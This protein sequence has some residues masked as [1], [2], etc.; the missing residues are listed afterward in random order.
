MLRFVRGQKR[1]LLLL[2]VMMVVVFMSLGIHSYMLYQQTLETEMTRLGAMANSQAQFLVTLYQTAQTDRQAL[3][4][5]EFF[6][7]LLVNTYQ[8]W[9][10]G[11]GDT[12][13]VTFAHYRDGKIEF[14]F[15]RHPAHDHSVHART[16]GPETE[17]L[18]VPMHRALSGG[19]GVVIAPD[20]RGVPVLAAY[21]FIAPLALG[22]VIKIDLAEIRAPL[23]DKLGKTALVSLLLLVVGGVFFI[24]ISEGITQQIHESQQTFASIFAGASDGILLMESRSGCLTMANGSFCAMVGCA[25]DEIPRLALGDLDRDGVLIQFLAQFQHNDEEM[26]RSISDVPL[27][28]RDGTL[29]YADINLSM[30]VLNRRIHWLILCRDAT[31]RRQA[32]TIR[33]VNEDWLRYMTA[34]NHWDI[35]FNVQALCDQALE[36]AETLTHSQAGFLYLLNDDRNTFSLRSQSGDAEACGVSHPSHAPIAE[37]GVWADSV[38]SVHAT[39]CND[40]PTLATR[41]GLPAGHKPITRYASVPVLIQG[42]VQMILVVGNKAQPYDDGDIQQLQIVGNDVMNLIMRK[43]WEEQLAQSKEQA[44]AA[45]RA[46]ADFLAAMSHEIRTPMNGVLGMADLILGTPLTDQQRH[47]VETIHR[48]GRTLLRIINDILDLSKIQAGQLLLDPIPFDLGEVIRDI[49]DLFEDGAAKKGLGFHV[50]VAQGV[51]VY[52]LGDPYRLNQI[53][54]NLVG[55]AIKFTDKGRVD[56]RVETLEEQEGNLLLRFQITDTGIGIAP[57]HH[58]RLFQAFSQADPSISRRFGGTG[59]GLVIVQRLVTM[60]NGTLSVESA[61]GLGSCFSFTARF[62]QQ[63]AADRPGDCASPTVPHLVTPDTAHFEQ[64]ILLVEDNPVNQEVATETLKLFGCQ[65]TVANDGQQA[66]AIVQAAARPFGA[67]FMDCEMPVLDGFETTRRLRQWESETGRP[68]TPII[69]LTAHVLEQSR[70]QCQEAGM[71]D[72]LVKPFSQTALG[73]IL[74]RWLPQTGSD[75]VHK[76]PLHAAS[77]GLEHAP[78]AVPTVSLST[79]HLHEKAIPPDAILDQQ[80]LAHIQALARQGHSN[81]L[82]RMVAHYLEQTPELLATLED[83]L[84]RNDPEGV[85]LAAHTLKSSSL[86]MGVARLAAL[87]QKIEAEHAN[88]V[89]SRQYFAL[90]AAAFVEAKYALNILGTVQYSGT[91]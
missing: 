87:G 25:Q 79:D 85:R 27:Y 53:L 63:Q 57:E 78:D 16:I 40:Y 17:P 81:L 49:R 20:Y 47:Y 11:L 1:L 83:A 75:S 30:I 23:F 42:Q 52:L 33:A 44:E 84:S 51:P 18:S 48:S 37:A 24:R 80:V 14:L 19:S 54:F 21:E 32:Y 41:R 46:K 58:A 82:E 72:Y 70:K 64:T 76:A 13:E 73:N 89:L 4:N 39:I 62:G 26:I 9:H 28:R 45:T 59:L 31:Y 38:R 8:N 34:L 3:S 29:R 66:I 56:V 55:N 61:P 22:M 74:H 91:E 2:I 12:G 43:R 67:L 86:T 88:L 50:E 77:H 10:K 35:E 15:Q 71:D 36:V 69:A 90:S 6:S 68:R 65:V 5:E 7:N 60:M